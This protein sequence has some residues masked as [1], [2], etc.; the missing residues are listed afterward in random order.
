MLK[1]RAVG[2][3][4]FAQLSRALSVAE[5]GEIQRSLTS[6]DFLAWVALFCG[7][8]EQSG[9]WDVALCTLTS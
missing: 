5:L 3:V 4:V 8:R 1:G 2:Y 6:A 7:L 9:Y